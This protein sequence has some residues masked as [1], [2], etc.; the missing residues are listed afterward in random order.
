MFIR[1]AFIEEIKKGGK[2]RLR[3]QAR[4]GNKE[5]GGRFKQREINLRVYG[6]R[7]FQESDKKR[8]ERESREKGERRKGKVNTKYTL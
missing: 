2:N 5:S 3:F 8:R 6:R 7:N 1:F 4:E